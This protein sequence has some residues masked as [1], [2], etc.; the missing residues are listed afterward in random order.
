LGIPYGFTSGF[1]IGE[2]SRKFDLKNVISTNNKDF[3]WEKWSKFAKISKKKYKS[4][5]FDNKFQLVA[6]NIEGSWLLYT[7]IS[8]M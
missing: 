1:F 3:S 5:D 8:G 4:P 2:F 6:K 7:F